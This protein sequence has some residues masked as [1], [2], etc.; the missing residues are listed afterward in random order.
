VNALRPTVVL[1][2]L[3]LFSLTGCGSSNHAPSSTAIVVN[4]RIGPVSIGEQRPKVEAAIGAGHVVATHKPDSNGIGTAIVSYPAA[5]FR[6][7]YI[8]HAGKAAVF[9]A[10]TTS[11]RY[12]TQ[13]GVGVGSAVAQVKKIGASCAM[14]SCSIREGNGGAAVT[15]FI[16]DAG[17][18]RVIR[19]VIG[20]E[21]G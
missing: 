17:T 7:V 11:S 3:L 15:Y 2:T 21:F 6:V 20:V 10:Q 14:T 18:A 9:G 16:L 5:S 1:S 12:R 4:K 19:V 8:T 13:S